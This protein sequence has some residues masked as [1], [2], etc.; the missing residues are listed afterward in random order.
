MLTPS[1]KDLLRSQQCQQLIANEIRANQAP[2][3]FER[4][5]H[6]CL[7]TQGLGYYESGSE[8]FG[9]QGDFTTSPERSNF[10]AAAFARHIQRM[11]KQLGQFCIVE[12][13]A[14]SGRFAAD[15]IQALEIIQC[16]PERYYIVEK[17]SSLKTRQKKILEKTSSS[18]EVE[19]VEE[20]Q[21]PIECGIIIANEV[22]DALPVRLLI[23]RSNTILERCVGLSNTSEFEFVDVPADEILTE[24]IRASLPGEVL[25][26]ANDAYH[27]EIN[28]L[29]PG[30]VEYIA[31]F[32][33]KGIF[34]YVDYGYPRQEYYLQQR[35]MGTLIC[36]Y[37]HAA[38]EQPL[39]WPGLQDIS[40]NVDFTSLAEAAIQS[41]L[42]VNCYST[43]AHFL[44]ASN[45]LESRL[46][47]AQNCM[48][49]EDQAQ[50]K[51]LMMPGEMG[52]RFQV[53]V[54]SKNMQ[55]Q[56]NQFTTRDL[57]HRL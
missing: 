8:I 1:R 34:F 48:S 45:I 39:L 33:N 47:E 38:N 19:W 3:N 16:I 35:S 2:I 26:Q 41:G 25:N 6:L 17:S 18:C 12:V 21:A 40:C 43:Q 55:L 5:M 51:R 53:M 4:Y 56:P 32:V 11:Q 37:R 42:E 29:L 52:E 9:P 24:R 22:L 23:V 7:Y 50:I 20:L 31:S 27:T 14:G 10:F 30:F 57:L 15:L 44:L 54:L 13:G 49:L 46:Q 28:F 36:H